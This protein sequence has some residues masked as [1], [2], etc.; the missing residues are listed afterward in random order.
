MAH[1]PQ[2]LTLKEHRD[3]GH[4]VERAVR[5]SVIAVLTA[6]S[7]AALLNVFGQHPR[8]TSGRGA[9]AELSV[10]AP[11]RLRGGL[12]FEGR[13]AVE[14]R[15][16]IDDAVLVLDPGWLEQMHVN[17]IEPAPVEESGRDGRLS[18]AYGR[19]EAGERLVVYMQFQVNPTNVGRRSQRVELRDGPELL[20]SVDR[21]VT[22]FP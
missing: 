8:A 7:V 6:I 1:T 13:F 11:T 10:T 12:F 16:A 2:Y 19:V 20:A 14:A 9:V 5:W 15:E 21:A 22:V 4:P 17:T 18:L 3:H